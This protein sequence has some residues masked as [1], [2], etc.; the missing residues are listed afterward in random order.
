M[1]PIRCNSSHVF[2][3]CYYIQMDEQKRHF[4]M[5]INRKHGEQ[6]E[7]DWAGDSATI[8]DSDTGE[9]TPDFIFVACLRIACIFTLKHSLTKNR[10]RG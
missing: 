1:S 5:H 8:I 3:F 7:V 9:T 4:T 6:I 2:R 10:V